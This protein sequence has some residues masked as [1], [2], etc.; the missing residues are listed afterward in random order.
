MD[1]IR[2]DSARNRLMV[3]SPELAEVALKDPHIVT[4]VSHGRGEGAGRLPREGEA[5]DVAGFFEMWYTV[6]D[7]YARF[8][9]ELRKAFT[10]RAVERFADGMARLADSR[11][12]GLPGEGDLAADYL[13]PYIMD[14]TFLL[15]GV[16]E[17]EWPR[18]AKV[19]QLVIHLFKQQLRGYTEPSEKERS[20]FAI[21]MTY[22]KAL[23]DELL[24]GP[25]D[26]PFVQAARRLVR[27]EDGNWPIAALIGQLLMAGIEP[28]ITGASVTCR[29]I[30]SDPDLLAGLR[31]GALDPGEVAEE[32]M[33]HHPPFGNIFRFVA[34]PCD[35]LGVPLSPGTV[36]AIDVA[37]INQERVPPRPLGQ[38]CPLRSSDVLTFGKG[39]HYC[40][41][42]NSARL[43]ISIAVRRLVTAEPAIAVEAD[44]MVIDTMNNLKEVRSLPYVKGGPMS[45]ANHPSHQGQ[46]T[47]VDPDEIPDMPNFAILVV[48]DLSKSLE[49]YVDGLGFWVEKQVEGPDGQLAVVHLRRAQYRDMLLRP[50]REPLAGPLGRGVRL[51]FTVNAETEASM[52]EIAERLEKLPQ[53]TVKGPLATPWNTVD[54]EAT[55]PD[56]YV[57]VLTTVADRARTWT[58]LKE[59]VRASDGG[60]GA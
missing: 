21:A 40:L 12:D 10:T 46:P 44:R 50:A 43:Q 36:L 38:G 49:W 16:P 30:W 39:L 41:G 20:A 3:L 18:L 11:L 7:D 56:G 24:A 51:S 25:A 53:G 47:G 60:A 55:D 35:C 17:E 13:G 4:G 58:E 59:S 27:A 42:A 26:T 54:V 37:A 33:R 2:W 19:S 29:R 22:L 5:P 1:G 48:S 15:L 32:V 57:V 23:T 28:M 34:E 9:S 45:H 31:T 14:S 8:N 52:R 6:G